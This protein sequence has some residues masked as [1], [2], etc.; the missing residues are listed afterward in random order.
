MSVTL[1]QNALN[2]GFDFF[3]ENLMNNHRARVG[4]HSS[5]FCRTSA[6]LAGSNSFGVIHKNEEDVALETVRERDALDRRDIPFEGDIRATGTSIA[7][8]GNATTAASDKMQIKPTYVLRRKSNDDTQSREANFKP[9]QSKGRENECSRKNSDRQDASAK[10]DEAEVREQLVENDEFGLQSDVAHSAALGGASTNKG[11]SARESSLSIE[12]NNSLL[13]VQDMN[14]GV[15]STREQQQNVLRRVA[16]ER[17]NNRRAEAVARV[18]NVKREENVEEENKQTSRKAA[19]KSR[20]AAKTRAFRYKARRKL[21]KKGASSSVNPEDTNISGV[22]TKEESVMKQVC[23]GLFASKEENAR[24]EVK[25]P[26]K[27]T[28]TTHTV[29][30]P[31]ALSPSESAWKSGPPKSLVDAIKSSYPL[32][33]ATLADVDDNLSNSVSS[34]KSYAKASQTGWPSSN[35]ADSCNKVRVEPSCFRKTGV[36]L[37][38]LAHLTPILDVLFASIALQHA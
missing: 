36:L 17:R 14:N 12:A 15:T 38:L 7:L 1:Q 29:P 27:T 33:V 19:A 9:R 20:R 11:E 34:S 24:A 30:V 25:Y 37:I 23:V 28:E 8:G 32:A 2:F 16:L 26:C 18:L 13:P 31:E 10:V 21:R 22:S 5:A 6:P 4:S 3:R 35:K